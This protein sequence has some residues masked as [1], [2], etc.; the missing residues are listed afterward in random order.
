MAGERMQLGLMLHDP[1]EE[2]DCFSDNTHNSHYDDARGIYNVYH[3][4]YKRIDG[5]VV[6]GASLSSLVQEVETGLDAEMRASLDATAAAMQRMKEHRRFRRDGLR[7][8]AGESNPEGNAL[9]SDVVEALKAQTRVIERVAVALGV[10]SLELEGI[11]QPGRPGRRLPVV[12]RRRQ[13]R[14]RSLTAACLDPPVKQVL[15]PSLR[16]SGA[17]CVNAPEGTPP[18]RAHRVVRRGSGRGLPARLAKPSSHH[19]EPVRSS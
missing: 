14:Q 15:L 12:R 11:R 2:H 16:R 3:G 13:A 19:G 5:S 1:E 18:G 7:P 17:G 8:D 4:R 6:E 10:E 9:V